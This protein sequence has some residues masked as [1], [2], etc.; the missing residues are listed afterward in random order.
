MFL[1]KGWSS[2]NCLCYIVSAWPSADDNQ[3]H[4]EKIVQEEEEEGE[5][6]MGGGEGRKRKRRRA[7]RKRGAEIP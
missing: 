7:L 1:E 6:K 3:C 2:G 5:E 4:P